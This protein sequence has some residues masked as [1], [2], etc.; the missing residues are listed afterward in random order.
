MKEI[1]W[2]PIVRTKKGALLVGEIVRNLGYSKIEV[3]V[4]YSA[5]KHL[6]GIEEIM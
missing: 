3:L 5:T 2:I 6:S 1:E 4:L